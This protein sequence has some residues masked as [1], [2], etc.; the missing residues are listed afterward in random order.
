M[1]EVRGNDCEDVWGDDMRFQTPRKSAAAEVQIFLVSKQ[2]RSEALERYE[3]QN[4]FVVPLM[5]RPADHS[6]FLEWPIRRVVNRTYASHLRSIS[7]SVDHRQWDESSDESAESW[8]LYGSHKYLWGNGIK[9]D[10]HNDSAKLGH[11]PVVEDVCQRAAN[12][13]DDVY[14][15]FPQLR[16]FQ[17]NIQKC[18]LSDELSPYHRQHTLMDAMAAE[19]S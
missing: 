13:I 11:D 14:D 3:S 8:R 17:I 2:I 10:A 16:K 6:R 19:E 15:G 5:R 12:L 9:S 1:G 4:H 7:I 18:I